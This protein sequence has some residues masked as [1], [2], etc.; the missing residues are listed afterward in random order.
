MAKIFAEEL[1]TI[2][3]GQGV[4]IFWHNMDLSKNKVPTEAEYLLMVQQKTG[5]LPRLAAR[6]IG[7]LLDLEQKEVNRLSKFMES[8]GVAFQ[9]KDD[10]LNLTSELYCDTKGTYA[11][12]I[13]E[14]FYHLKINISSLGKTNFNCIKLLRKMWDERQRQVSRDTEAKNK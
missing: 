11:E 3:L 5:V 1:V 4:D 7:V 10:I 13:T 6:L 12:D 2:H 14:V 8:L 9:I